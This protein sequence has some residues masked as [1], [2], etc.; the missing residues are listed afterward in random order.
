LRVFQSITLTTCIK[1]QVYNNKYT[2]S[3]KS[4]N[5]FWWKIKSRQFNVHSINLGL[6]IALR[7]LSISFI[8]KSVE[9]GSD[10]I[11][12]VYWES[13]INRLSHFWIQ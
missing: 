11:P 13:Q 10:D 12:G 8:V 7:L 1:K 6:N 9:G 3:D 2:S 5:P 4:H